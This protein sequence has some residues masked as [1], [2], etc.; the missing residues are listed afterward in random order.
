MFLDLIQDVQRS[1]EKVLRQTTKSDPEVLA[2]SCLQY[3][4]PSLYAVL[5][6]GLRETLSTPF[7]PIPN[8][9]WAVVEAS[10]QQGPMTR[11]LHEL[12]QRL[13]REFVLTEPLLKVNAFFFGLLK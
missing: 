6:D 8:S 7:G 9:V 2:Q 4:C 12:V 10:A 1:V 3:L 5:N 13:N 11:A